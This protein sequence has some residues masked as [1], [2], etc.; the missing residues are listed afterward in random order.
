MWAFRGLGLLAAGVT[1]LAVGSATGLEP[2]GRTVAAIGVLTLR[3]VGTH[4]RRTVLGI[5]IA[6]AFLSMWVSNTATTLMMLPIALSVLA[7]PVGTPPNAIVFGSGTVTIGQ[8]ARGG[9][10]LNVVGVLLITLFSR[11]LGGWA[12]GL[13]Y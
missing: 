7:L 4:P 10:V 11:L 1:W 3:A 6:T 2:A 5:M 12:L 13:Q 8:M 9:A